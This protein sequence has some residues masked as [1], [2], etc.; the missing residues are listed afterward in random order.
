MGKQECWHCGGQGWVYNWDH[1][2]NEN[3]YACT[4]GQ[5]RPRYHSRR[6]SGIPAVPPAA[7]PSRLRQK[8]TEHFHP[9]K[10]QG[11]TP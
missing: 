7:P 6:D 5:Q 11:D 1:G 3:C 10:V 9:E 8:L 4:K 2:R